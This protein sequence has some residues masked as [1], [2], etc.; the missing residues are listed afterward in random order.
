MQV[1]KFIAFWVFFSA[2]FSSALGALAAAAYGV[3]AFFWY[4]KAGQWVWITL[5]D[6]GPLA[7]LLDRAY[8]SALSNSWIGLS[9][10]TVWLATAPIVLSGT[11]LLWFLTLVFFPMMHLRDLYIEWAGSYEHPPIQKYDHRHVRQDWRNPWD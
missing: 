4:L 7:R 5:Y 2:A 11:V 6:L 8:A 10:L 3:G 1:F 9:E